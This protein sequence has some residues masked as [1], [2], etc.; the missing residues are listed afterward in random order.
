MDWVKSTFK[1]PITYTYELRDRGHYRFLLPP[2][3]IVP[4]GE[5]TLDSLVAMFEECEILG[6]PKIA[7]V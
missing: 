7:L 4:T 6:Y 3:F 2:E 5:E 1:T